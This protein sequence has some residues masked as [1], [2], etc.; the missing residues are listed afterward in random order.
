MTRKTPRYS[1]DDIRT[2]VSRLEQLRQ[3][4]RKRKKSKA[5]FVKIPF[6]FTKEL[7]GKERSGTLHCSKEEVEGY[8]HET[9]SDPMREEALGQCPHEVKVGPAEAMIDVK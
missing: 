9:H 3:K 5:R 4:K 7:P 6:K 2:E 8:L 1:I